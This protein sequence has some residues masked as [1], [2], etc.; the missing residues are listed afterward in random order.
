MKKILFS[1]IG[2]VVLFFVFAWYFNASIY[3]EMQEAQIYMPSDFTSYT[4]G[5][6][7]SEPLTYAAIGD[8]LTAGTGVDT[9]TQS[10]PYLIAQEIADESKT[11][12]LKPFAVPGVR[13][14]YV[15]ENFL[16]PAVASNPDIITLLIGINDIHGKVSDKKFQENYEKILTVLTQ[17]TNAKIY[18]INLPYIGTEELISLPYRDYFNW[19]T[20]QYNEI[21]KKMAEKYSVTYIDLYT[22]H[23]PH[24][25][26]PS[27]YAA[28]FFHPNTLGYSM[29]AEFMY[30]N[31]SK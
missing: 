4:L 24:A 14:A 2:I 15:L 21:I 8:S 25:L 23:M 9:Y 7:N 28:D 5:S 12:L 26:N 16:E 6:S 20:Q 1:L 31:F 10:Y 11:I 27:Y 13:S 30:A 3:W 22:A 18:A 19:R 17:E 29:W